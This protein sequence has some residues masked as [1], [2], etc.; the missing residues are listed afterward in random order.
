MFVDS[1]KKTIRV[2]DFGIA[3]SDSKITVDQTNAGSIRY[4]TPEVIISR[5]P[6]H[7][8]IDVWA[9]G[10]ILYWMLSGHPPFEG[11]TRQDIIDKILKADY[12]FDRD[13]KRR[14]TRAVR[15]IIQRM[16][17]IDLKERIDMK[18]IHDHIWM[19]K[20]VAEM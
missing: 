16:L 17:T 18:D 2:V 11:N 4:L 6:A 14:T 20:T 19:N 13:M 10:V 8:G 1:E 5:H 7:P 9:M 15:D 12:S 3:G